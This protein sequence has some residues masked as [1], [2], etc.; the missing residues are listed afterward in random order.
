[1]MM[2]RIGLVAGE[3]SCRC[4]GGQEIITAS[5]MKFVC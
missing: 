4:D 3:N 2:M 5:L 1:M